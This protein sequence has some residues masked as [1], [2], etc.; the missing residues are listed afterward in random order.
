MTTTPYEQHRDYVLAVL[1]RRCRW[2]DG[3]EREEVLHDAY[4][5]FLQKQ[6]DGVLDTD[7]MRPQQVRA[8]LVQ[9]AINKAMDDGKSARRKRSVGL[10]EDGGL[11]VADQRPEVVERLAQ[12]YDA[13]R[14]R[15]IVD[16]LPARQQVVIKLR[17]FLDLSPTEIQQYLGITERVYRRELER[18]MRALTD[19]VELVQRGTSCDQRRSLILAYVAGIA[20][21][22]RQQVARRHLATCP[23]CAAWAGRL[24]TAAH[25]A[26]AVV[27]LPLAS[28]VALGGDDRWW[29]GLGHV[30]EATR[31]RIVD[32][33]SGGRGHVTG[34][35]L[36]TDPASTAVLGAARPGTIAAVVAGCLTVGGT[37][38][39]AVDGVTT[40]LGL[41][42]SSKVETRTHDHAAATPRPAPR[43]KRHQAAATPARAAS[44]P[45]L[46]AP[47]T[48]TIATTTR[49]T[50]TVAKPAE[51]PAHRVAHQTSSEFGIESGGTSVSS[52]SSGSS[53]SGSG[54][55]SGSSAT[56]TA[57]SA[58]STARSS[59]A[60]SSGSSSGHG[61]SEAAV[62]AEFGP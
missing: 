19:H 37:T 46:A 42:A 8:Y 32:V 48:S 16:E 28:H 61:A 41:L 17:F 7:A 40:P 31:D 24:R 38:Y 20:G 27:P 60:P 6:R 18:A 26:G 50:A 51:T 33:A 9:T 10:E 53:S 15:E 21:P 4:A 57:A 54:S 43:R 34:L 55:S 35:A 5:V 25:Q 29:A 56:A 52:G 11:E 39:C 59:P 44:T 14:V 22:N 2:L 36:R 58:T 45:T 62:A 49:R 23:A 47:T 1:A 30:L 13:E 12:S 3:G